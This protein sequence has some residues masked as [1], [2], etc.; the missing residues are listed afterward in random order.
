MK[1]NDAFSRDPQGSALCERELDAE[2]S[3]AGRG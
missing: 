3:P 2:R 1:R